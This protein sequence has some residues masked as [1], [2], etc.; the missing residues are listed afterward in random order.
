MESRVEV[1]TVGLRAVSHEVRAGTRTPA[2][3][4]ITSHN[5]PER[6]LKTGLD[7]SS[8]AFKNQNAA[9]QDAWWMILG[10]GGWLNGPY[11][12]CGASNPTGPNPNP[13]PT[14]LNHGTEHLTKP[15]VV[16]H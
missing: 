13:S 8:Y 5:A 11:P 7:T 15:Q 6:L 3:I 9:S 4:V 1:G 2:H 10:G 14:P 12:T 16:D